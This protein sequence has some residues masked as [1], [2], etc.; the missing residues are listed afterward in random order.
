MLRL[1]RVAVVS[2]G[3]RF[4]VGN[5][6]REGSRGTGG[7]R[8]TGSEHKEKKRE[9]RQGRRG[10][11]GKG[12]AFSERALLGEIVLQVVF[13]VR[14]IGHRVVAE[15]STLPLHDTTSAQKNATKTCKTFV[16]NLL[17]P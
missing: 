9:R 10:R 12:K 1:R 14:A 8:R 11:E 15:G 4:C 6:G 13:E 2:G 5:S 17:M 7:T 3:G 16:G